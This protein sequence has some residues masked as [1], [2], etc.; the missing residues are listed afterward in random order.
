MLEIIIFTLQIREAPKL[1]K[2]F[3]NKFATKKII[4]DLLTLN[5]A[6]FV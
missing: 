4:Y 5:I 2:V 3:G 1:I 6:Y